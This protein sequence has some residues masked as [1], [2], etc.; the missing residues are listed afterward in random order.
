MLRKNLGIDIGTKQISI[1]SIEEGLLLHEPSVAAVDVDTN[2]VVEA[3]KPALRLVDANPDRLRLCWPVWDPIVKSADILSSM[4]RI[5]LRRAVGRTMLRPQ[6]MVSI[7]C[8]LTE[9]QTNALEDAVLSAGASRVHLLESP[10]CAALGVGLDFSSPVGQLIVHIGASRTEVAM[11]FIGEMVT[12]LTVPVGGSAF[13]SAIIEYM[14]KRHNLFIGKRTAEQI[15]L[16]IGT[17]AKSAEEKHLDVKGR[18]MKT[19]EPRIVTLSSKEML[20]ALTEPLTSILDA[21]VSVIEQTGDD[22]RADIAKGGVVLTGGA[23]LSGMDQFL[24]EVMGLRIRL[25]ANA[26]TAAV[27]GAAVALSRL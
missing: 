7:P 18:C 14:R 21:I 26:E 13:D 15:K 12:H 3:G 8:D 1:Y 10:L 11:I 6:I 16:R 19:K 23:V 27:E 25:A 20:G 4:L 9:A 22:M 24:D 17:I 2:D 5:L